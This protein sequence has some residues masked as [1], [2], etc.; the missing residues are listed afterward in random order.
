MT[1]SKYVKGWYCPSDCGHLEQLD[2]CDGNLGFEDAIDDL[3][4]R[5]WDRVE[6]YVKKAVQE[7]WLIDKEC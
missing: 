5:C 3:C 7:G 6:R 1:V 2:M 4:G